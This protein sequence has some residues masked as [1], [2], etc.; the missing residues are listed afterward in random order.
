MI[1]VCVRDTEETF[2][3]RKASINF[4]AG[5][6]LLPENCRSVF[7]PIIHIPESF[8][9]PLLPSL[10]FFSTALN[11]ARWLESSL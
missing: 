1:C 11:M 9:L 8:L 10:F 6:Q 5:G 3:T 7:H 2:H 4:A